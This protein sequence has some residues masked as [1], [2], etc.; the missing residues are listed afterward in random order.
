[1][2]NRFTGLAGQSL[3]AAVAICGCCLTAFADE[4][5]SFQIPAQA[6]AK[7]LNLYA[8]QADLQFMF[9]Y[10]A[11]KDVETNEVVG[12]FDKDVA[13]Q[14]LLADT[15]LEVVYG[16]N[17]TATV[18]PIEA[19]TDMTEGSRDSG[20]SQPTPVLMAQKQTSAPQEQTMKRSNESSTETQPPLEIEEII[21]TGSNIRGVEAVGVDVITLDRNYIEHSGI[22]TTTE[23]IQTLP[24]NVGIGNEAVEREGIVKNSG[25][26]WGFSSGVSLRGLGTDSTLMLLNGRR[27]AG[28]GNSANFV[29]LNTIPTAAI[30]RIDVL[31]DGA[32]AIYG[33]DALGGVV[34]VILR[35][36]YEG[37]ETAIR[38]APGTSD[39]D[40]IQFNQMFGKN[41]GNGNV[42]FSYEYYD[43]SELKSA[44]RIYARDSDLT[45]LGGGDTSSNGSNPGNIDRYTGPAGNTSVQLAIPPNQDGTAL[46]PADLLPGVTNLLNIREGSY[47]LPEQTRHSVFVSARQELSEKVEMF[48]EARYSTREFDRLNRVTQRLTLT[49]P[50]TNAFFVD[51]SPLGDSTSIRMRYSTVDDYGPVR[52]TGDVDV[53]G[54]VL[55]ANV[56]LSESWQLEVFGSIGSEDTNNLATGRVNRALL[57]DALADSDPATAFNPFGDGSFTNPATL[58]ALEGFLKND[59]ES[60]LTTVDAR[61]DGDLFDM[62]GGAAKLAV[63]AQFRD[64]SLKTTSLEFDTTPVPVANPFG[65]D[66]DLE[67]DVTAVFAEIYL[68]FVTE[69]NSRPG[70]KKL[71][72]SIAGRYE[73]Y[74]DFG[75]TANPKFGVSWSP[76][77]SLMFR[78]SAGTSFRA[79]QL[80]ELDPSNNNIRLINLPDLASPTGRTMT[81]LSLGKSPDLVP[82]EGTSWTA[83]FD[84][85]P[86]SLP[87]FKLGVTYFSTEVDDIIQVPVS[88]VISVLLDPIGN[89]PIITFCPETAPGVF[90][91]DVATVTALMNHPQFISTPIPPEQVGAIADARLQNVANAELS[92]ID[93]S[94][95]YAFETDAGAFD[96]SF[97]GSHVLEFTQQLLNAPSVDNV[98]RVGRPNSLN[99]RSS[100]SWNAGGMNAGVT[101]RHIG[102]YTDD[103]GSVE[104]SLDPCPVDSWT[105][106]DLRLGYDFGEGT[107]GFLNGIRLSLYVRN[108]F[109]E[110]PPF[111]YNSFSAVGFDPIN[112]D[113][114]GRFVSFQLNKTW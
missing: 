38:Y 111:V 19:A 13:L 31:A 75:D 61:L 73:D 26:N 46:T 70:I 110:D 90:G 34:N 15:G 106:W 94:L 97:Y 69:Q 33:S 112:A 64:Q 23:L 114:M 35:D 91:C 79:P 86:I 57:A 81:I 72:V 63:G 36:D 42:L 32:S 55:G 44:D 58:A 101:V 52:S 113:P 48:G 102:D 103:L 40:E 105:T 93:L 2:S 98:D 27:S 109:D 67:R 25:V 107:S 51:P 9:P 85:T 96:L 68:P 47:I 20:N 54:L 49:I 77:D 3:A 95:T 5:V 29:D 74:S 24:Q 37:A 56:A 80:T 45:P 7:G 82:Q 59:V 16:E 100:L 104:C 50:N 14:T 89:A 99:L 43:R 6:A 39:I 1:M 53:V 11:V 87:G 78:G 108:V 30:E 21:V 28:G 4:P 76:T 41:W 92:G 12:Q 88:S 66:V 22:S 83:G 17:N 18:R 62:A 84:V 65:F 8:E 60:E 10:A 71:G